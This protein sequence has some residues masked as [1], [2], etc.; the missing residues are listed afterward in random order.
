M[1]RAYFCFN[2]YLDIERKDDITGVTEDEL[3]KDHDEGSSIFH[4]HSR[5]PEVFPDRMHTSASNL[6]ATWQISLRGISKEKKTGQQLN[7]YLRDCPRAEECPSSGEL[8]F[9][10]QSWTMGESPIHLEI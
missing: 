3:I 1:S 9:G 5:I 10:A 6:S 7:V 8:A 4:S 2:L